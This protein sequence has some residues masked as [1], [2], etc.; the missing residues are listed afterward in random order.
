[1]PD[2]AKNPAKYPL[3]AAT[4]YLLVPGERRKRA[5]GHF[6]KAGFE[7]LKGVNALAK[8]AGPEEG[9]SEAKRGQRQS[10]SID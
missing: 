5:S 8:P 7:A 2:S 6:R 3:L 10:I 4:A 1:M 9:S